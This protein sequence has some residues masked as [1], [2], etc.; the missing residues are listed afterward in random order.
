MKYI[1]GETVEVGD[2]VLIERGRTPGVVHAI[3]ESL[4]QMIE[5]GVDE[6]GLSIKSEPFGLVFWPTSEA[7]NPVIF[8]GRKKPTYTD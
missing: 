2:L 1:T 5:W 8:N 3:V 4:Q 6:A 7:E